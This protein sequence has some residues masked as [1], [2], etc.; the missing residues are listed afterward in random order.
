MEN[1]FL[2]GYTVKKEGYCVLRKSRQED[3]YTSKS[4]KEQKLIRL[5]QRDKNLLL[6]PLMFQQFNSP[7]Y[8]TQ[9][10]L[11]SD[12]TKI[13]IKIRTLSHS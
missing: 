2:L 10:S 11:I 6:V 1:F 5:L 4:S 8:L 7:D 3:S 13:F 9:K 12:T